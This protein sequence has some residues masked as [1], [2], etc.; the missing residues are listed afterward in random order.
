VSRGGLPRFPKPP[1]PSQ[2]PASAGR[3]NVFRHLLSTRI[4]S[5]LHFGHPASYLTRLEMLAPLL[6]GVDHLVFNG[7]SVE[8]RF[9]KT[10]P[11]GQERFARLQEFVARYSPATFLT[12]NHDPD[13]TPLHHLDLAENSLFITHGDA[14]FPGISPWSRDAVALL[15]ACT[16]ALAALPPSPTLS[17]R[18]AA[19]RRAI[20]TQEHIGPR[21]HHLAR[22]R[23]LHGFV[24]EAWPPTRPF[25]MLQC[26]LTSARKAAAFAMNHRPDSR[27]VVMG[28]THRA[29]IRKIGP[30]HI[31]NT[32]S[33]LPYSGRLLV[34]LAGEE[35]CIRRIDRRHDGFH[36]GAMVARVLLR[37]R[38]S[39]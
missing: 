9:A 16:E 13:I 4:L 38:P 29:G 12:G 36:P 32:G 33:F 7:D 2:H 24:Q 34:D 8:T 20:L 25:I 18:L 11:E 6:E 3:P 27:A 5:D 28:H 37:D 30:R 10:R 39:R 35:L 19:L 31:I 23:T 26:W 15:R 21:P 22:T 1:F 17:E 14:F